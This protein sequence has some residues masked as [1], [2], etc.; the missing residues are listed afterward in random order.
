MVFWITSAF[1]TNL[2]VTRGL[3]KSYQQVCTA[4][5]LKQRAL[6]G[7]CHGQGA[8]IGAYGLFFYLGVELPVSHPK[9]ELQLLY[10]LFKA[11]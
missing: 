9:I 4:Y 8:Y 6:R 10:L 2:W 7:Y 11:L 5:R 3:L 1:V